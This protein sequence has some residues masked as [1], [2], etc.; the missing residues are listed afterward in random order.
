ME[1]KVYICAAVDETTRRNLKAAV[2]LKG[3]SIQELLSCFI[4]FYV[5]D[6]ATEMAHR[7]FG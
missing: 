5:D 4:E 7:L 1:R 2:A 3:I 6:V